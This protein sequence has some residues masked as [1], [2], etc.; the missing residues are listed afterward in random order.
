M[1]EFID[2]KQQ[3]AR[4]KNHIDAAIS[5]VL[6]HGQ[7]ILGPEVSEL[8]EKLA[9]FVGS[10]FC[11]TCANG[12][13]ALQ[14]V[15]MAMGIGP[16]DEV[17][18]PGFTYIA[19]AETVALLGAKPVYV[20]ID[21]LTYNLDP[22][23]LEEAIT[24]RTKAIIPVSLYGQCA[25]FDTI[26]EIAA[27][28]G[29]PVI[30]DAAQSFGA[31][32]KGRKSCNLSTVACTSFF[33]SKPL[34]CYGDGGAIFTDD[35]ELEKI[36]RQIARHGQDRRYHHVRVGVNSRLDT[37]QAAILL[38][39]LS[40]FDDELTLRVAVAGNYDRLLAEADITGTPFIAPGNVSVYAQYTLCVDNRSS[41]QSSLKDQGIPTVVHY[42][43]PL[44]QQPAVADESADLPIGDS[45][46]QRVL[47]LPMHP[48][49]THEQQVLVVAALVGEQR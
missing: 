11:I 12:T 13:D 21:P 38:Q 25:D 24:P 37:I 16:G 32:Y 3:Q 39:K 19:T 2:L 1:I 4:I 17:I 8:E 6:E 35:P 47:S 46:A 15:Q 30:E 36:M 29:I 28:H 14:I 10:K 20:D 26:N 18:T 34:G 9:S 42:P 45:V 41:W 22:K 31:T 27:R 5:R 23:K 33:P 40:I 49:L 48:Y 44:N 7:Y 43:I